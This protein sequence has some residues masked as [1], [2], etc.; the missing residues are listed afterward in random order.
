VDVAVLEVG[1]GGRLDATN[2]SD[3][4]VSAI[5]SI[6]FDHEAFLGRTL[7]RIAREKAGV[8]RPGRDCVLGPLP[9]A[10]RRAVALVARK[11]GARTVLAL[12][13]VRFRETRAGLEL[14]TPE[15]VYRGLR[16]LPGAHQRANLAVAVRVLE[17]VRRAGIRVSKD[18]VARGVSRV[19]W[20]GRLQWVDERP[21]LLLDG[22]H[23]PAGA[24]AL[25]RYLEG[26]E[27]FV[28]VF[29]VMRD[30]DVR[31]MA[32]ALFP[33]AGEIVLTS[34]VSRRA[35]APAEIARR[36]GALARRAHRV[37]D[38]RRALELA[39]RLAGRDGTVVV[40]GSLYL[41]GALLPR[42]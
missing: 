36:A 5:V 11:R 25:A 8:L 18:A 33:R 31:G 10:A 39:R 24:R 42:R 6:D 7:P 17:A 4:L 37:A 21:R 13:G 38:P 27:R 23:N 28:L 30:K 34:P 35:A 15:R 1:L 41:V 26:V 2:V 16:P 29:G 32:E 40:A 14:R 12:R 19:C 3:P 20:P 9:P 22:A